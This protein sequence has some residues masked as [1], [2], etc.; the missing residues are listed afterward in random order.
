MKIRFIRTKGEWDF[1]QTGKGKFIFKLMR[2]LTKM[3]VEC[4]TSTEGKCDIDF[5]VSRFHYE[6]KNCL[7]RVLRL[8]PVHVDTNMHY[9]W[10][11]AKKEKALRHSH[12]VIYQTVFSKKMCDAFIGKS[13]HL[14]TI[15]FNGADPQDYDV[16]A[17]QSEYTYNYLASTRTWINQKRLPDIVESFLKADIAD[18]VLYVAGILVKYKYKHPRIKYLGDIDEKTLAGYLK[19]CNAMIHTTWI[20]A[21]PNGVVESMVAGCPVIATN[22]GGTKELGV[23]TLIEDKPWKFKAM[24]LNKT[25]KANI[26]AL[27]EAIIKH[28]ERLPVKSEHLYIDNIAEQYLRFFKEVL[29]G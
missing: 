5:H 26:N 25:P 6:S 11:N 1:A 28:K 14:K 29:N 21:C 16:P 4:V 19:L 7:K 12:G 3:G 9:K 24:N 18:S 8:N 20:D 2:S 22:Q 17:A 13:R 10:L 23:Q 15:I 27:A